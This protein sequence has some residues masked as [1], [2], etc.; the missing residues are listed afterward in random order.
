MSRKQPG[1]R[2]EDGATPS[3]GAIDPGVLEAE[4]IVCRAWEQQLLERRDHMESA[5]EAAF[6]CCDTAYQHLAAAQR[7]GNPKTIISAHAALEKALE[8]A[9]KSSIAC[10]QVR[11]ASLA[12]LAWLAGRIDAYTV[13]EGATQSDQRGPVNDTPGPSLGTPKQ[14]PQAQQS[15]EVTAVERLLLHGRRWLA[16]IIM[17][18]QPLASKPATARRKYV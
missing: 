13:A 8:L 9:R 3:S 2:A 11:Q 10:N 4:N 12:E 18:D 15:P 16:Q 1:E 7:A 14:S 5:L 17:R 6:V